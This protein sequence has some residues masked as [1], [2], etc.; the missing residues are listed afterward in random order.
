MWIGLL[1]ALGVAL[2]ASGANLILA[3]KVNELREQNRRAHQI[4]SQIDEPR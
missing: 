3:V 1:V 2:I 4:L